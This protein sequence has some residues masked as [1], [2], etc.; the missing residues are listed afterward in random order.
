MNAN[1]ETVLRSLR[2]FGR[3]SDEALAIY[4]H[5]MANSDMSSSGVRSRR[6][7]LTRLGYVG[8]VGAVGT[9]SGRTAL[10]HAITPKGRLALR[11]QKARKAVAA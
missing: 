4:V 8:V 3:A 1:Q 9:K 10:V 11:S 7:E 5:H 6:A 2:S